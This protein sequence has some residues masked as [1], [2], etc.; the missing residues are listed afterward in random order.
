MKNKTICERTQQANNKVPTNNGHHVRIQCNIYTYLYSLYIMVHYKCKQYT[1][2]T[3]QNSIL[4]NN[5][6]NKHIRIKTYVLNIWNLAKALNEKGE[7]LIIQSDDFTDNGE[8][9][10]ESKNGESKILKLNN[11][12][13]IIS[14]W[15]GIFHG[16]RMANWGSS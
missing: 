7:I 13:F 2:T 5:V 14:N 3:Y 1:I 10:Y 11:L 9:V 6:Y 16:Q 15:K 8:I 12:F 4:F